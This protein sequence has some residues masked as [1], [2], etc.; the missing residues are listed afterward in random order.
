MNVESIIRVFGAYSSWVASLETLDERLWLTPVS[1][2]K[3]SVGQIVSHLL[4]WDQHH[5]QQIV[6]FLRDQGF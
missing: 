3:W 1:E 5:Q 2:G 4:N 6:S